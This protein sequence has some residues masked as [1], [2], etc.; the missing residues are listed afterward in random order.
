GD[1]GAMTVELLARELFGK[2]KARAEEKFSR[3]FAAY[4]PWMSNPERLDQFEK[5]A[6]SLDLLP[7]VLTD[8]RVFELLRKAYRTSAQAPLGYLFPEGEWPFDFFEG[9]AEAN[10][11]IEAGFARAKRNV[12]SVSPAFRRRFSVLNQ[13]IIPVRILKGQS[14]GRLGFSSHETRGA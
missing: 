14:T 12:M 13:T 5:L 3:R 2:L 6:D 8:R 9:T 7:P 11:E 1:G 4:Q 10:R